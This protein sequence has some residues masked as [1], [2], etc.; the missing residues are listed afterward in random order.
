MVYEYDDEDEDV[1][2][3]EAKIQTMDVNQMSFMTPSVSTTS[4]PS[5]MGAV[6]RGNI[7]GSHRG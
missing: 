6:I 1:L 2:K 7:G 3:L 5:H 4:T